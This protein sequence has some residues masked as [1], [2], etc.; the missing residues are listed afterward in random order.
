MNCIHRCFGKQD[1]NTL[2]QSL[3]QAKQLRDYCNF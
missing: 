1:T 2:P 3:I